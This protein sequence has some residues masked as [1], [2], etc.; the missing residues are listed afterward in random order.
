MLCGPQLFF[1]LFLGECIVIWSEKSHQMH[2]HQKKY[3]KI[4]II[5]SHKTFLNYKMGFIP[6]SS[7]QLSNLYDFSPIVAEP[8]FVQ[9]TNLVPYEADRE[10]YHILM[11][12]SR[13]FG[14]LLLWQ[15]HRQHIV[16]VLHLFL[17]W[18]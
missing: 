10:F 11:M 3:P 12:I 13:W 17:D 16:F 14:H 5:S 4:L 7:H 8:A 9:D 18:Q 1:G 2:F 6:S 15:H